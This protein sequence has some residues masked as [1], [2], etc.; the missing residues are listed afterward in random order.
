MHVCACIYIHTHVY[1]H[2]HTHTLTLARTLLYFSDTIVFVCMLARMRVYVHDFLFFYLESCVYMHGHVCILSVCIHAC[3]YA[4]LSVCLSVCVHA[5]MQYVYVC[6]YICVCIYIHVCILVS[7]YVH[8]SLLSEPQ[9]SK[10]CS[11]C[12][13]I[14]MHRRVYVRMYACPPHFWRIHV[15]ICKSMYV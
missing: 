3:L 4:H 10:Q 12:I 13:Y 2:T 6:K 1:T 8:I 15:Y 9:T 7:T 14:R 5:R 11:M